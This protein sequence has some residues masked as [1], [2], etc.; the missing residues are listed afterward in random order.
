VLISLW[1]FCPQELASQLLSRTNI[2][3]TKFCGYLELNFA[4]S[5]IHP[6]LGALIKFKT[7]SDAQ[8]NLE[9]CEKEESS[10]KHILS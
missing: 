3:I 1:L 7:S 10:R 8:E 9:V 2:S 6:P 4:G 5:P